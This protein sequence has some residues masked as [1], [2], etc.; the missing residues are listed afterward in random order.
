LI[1]CDDLAGHGS[2]NKHIAPSVLVEM[3]IG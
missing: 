2:G 3:L 1:H